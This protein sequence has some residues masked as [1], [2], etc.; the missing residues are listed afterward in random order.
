MAVGTAR[1][2][3]LRWIAA[4]VGLV[5]VVGAALWSGGEP[6]GAALE[7]AVGGLFD[8]IA[9]GR[10]EGHAPAIRAAAEEAEIDPN[11]VAAVCYM[12]SRGR[13]DALSAVGAAGLMQLMPDAAA[14]AAR[15]LG[16]EE[17][18]R[19]TLLGDAR[20]NLRLGARHLAWTLEH[21]GGETERALVAYN[22]GRTTLRRWI[23][24]AGGYTL[25]RERQV[26]DGD[27]RVLAYALGVLACRDTLHA[28]GKIDGPNR[29]RDEDERNEAD[30]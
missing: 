11:L 9:L 28:R 2:G 23:A 10:V 19:A 18:T 29:P 27:S 22:A 5:A 7:R 13:V 24:S 14:D 1:S 25:W 12:E 21:E 16:L 20:L 26:R 15:A 8:R 30:S 17:P 3:P 4:G 6:A